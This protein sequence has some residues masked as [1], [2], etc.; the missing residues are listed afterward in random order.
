MNI[1]KDIENLSLVVQWDGVED[2]IDTT[3]TVLWS[4]ETNPIRRVVTLT[5]QTSY[6]IITGLTLDTVYNIY[7]SASN[8]CGQ[9]PEYITSVLLATD[10]IST[11]T[12]TST[13]I[14]LPTTSPST[15][16]TSYY[17]STTTITSTEDT[18]ISEIT[19]TTTYTS[20]ID[21]TSIA[22]TTKAVSTTKT[23]TTTTTTT[24]ASTNTVVMTTTTTT[25][26]TDVATTINNNIVSSI[27]TTD[28]DNSAG[29][30]C[31]FLKHTITQGYAHI[32]QP[33]LQSVRRQNLK[34]F[35]V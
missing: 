14:V 27:P 26:T 12:M 25:S 34:P 1:T 15:K 8:M 23:T 6:I 22:N 30:T 33:N 3:Y 21:I 20:S 19:T 13:K 2:F 28:F 16:I 10:N 31:K 32:Q 18:I 5:E 24:I 35:A 9:G 11:T 7:V 17:A 29:S 4:S